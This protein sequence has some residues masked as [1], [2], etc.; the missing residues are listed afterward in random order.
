MHVSKEQ[1][2]KLD[3]KA[4]S[5]IFVGYSNEE[6]GYRLWNPKKKKV[7]RSRDIVFFEHEGIS[8]LKA[9]EITDKALDKGGDDQMPSKTPLEGAIKEWEIQELEHKIELKNQN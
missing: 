2:S 1:R 6:F 5:C 7:F 9:N 4:T 8:E 3:D